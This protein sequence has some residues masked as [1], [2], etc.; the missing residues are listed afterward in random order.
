[1]QRRFD[2]PVHERILALQK[3]VLDRLYHPVVLARVLDSEVKT[4][5]P[6]TIGALFEGLQTAIWEETSSPDETLAINSYRRSLQRAHLKKLIDMVLTG[7]GPPEDAR[8]MSRAGLR[9]LA[10]Q[11]RSTLGKDEL[12][13]RDETRAHLEE[14]LA[15]VDEALAARA[16]R[17]A[18]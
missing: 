14:S 15:R 7:G 8:T 12:T 18:F 6:F 11:L 2:Y 17:A 13:M 16:Q 10:E 1:M 4:E 5:D 3:R 9:S